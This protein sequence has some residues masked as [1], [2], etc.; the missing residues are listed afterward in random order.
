MSIEKISKTEFKI[1][2]ELERTVNIDDIKQQLQVVKDDNEKATE[3]EDWYETL[4]EDKKPYVIRLPIQDTSELEV[5]IKNLKNY[6]DN[7]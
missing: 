2:D 5:L 4:D 3:I 7:I 6:G 1:I